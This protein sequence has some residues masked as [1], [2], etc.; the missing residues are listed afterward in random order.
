MRIIQL[1]RHLIYGD[2]ICN[3]II[4]MD[5]ILSPRY[6]SI[7]AVATC[8]KLYSGHPRVVV[9]SELEELSIKED[10]IVIYPFGEYDALAYE[11]L[12]IPCKRVLMYQNV[13]Y[14]YYF[15]GI[16]DIVAV[17]CAKAQQYVRNTP[18]SFLKAIAP[19]AF[20]RKELIDMGWK[21]E[22]IY[23]LPL[24]VSLGKKHVTISDNENAA[25]Q[26]LFVGRIVPNKKIEDVIRVFDYY[27]THY[28]NNSQLRLAGSVGDDAYC[29]ALRKYINLNNIENV[30]FVGRVS[31][32]ELDKLYRSS[33][34]Y[35]CM[36]EHE[37]FCMPLIE[38]M[39]YEI[40]VVAYNAT[41]VPD[42][43]GDA[44]V[45]LESKYSE[46]V[47]EKINRIFEDESYR[48]EL[49]EGQNRHIDNYIRDDYEKK[50][51]DIIE[52]V[53]AISSNSY[54]DSSIEFYKILLEEIEKSGEKY[55][56]EQIQRIKDMDKP[57]VLY[58][59][60]KVGTTLL[61]CFKNNELPIEAICDA[62]K[63]GDEIEGKM[64]MSP[65]ECTQKYPEAIYI[66]T[67][68]NLS[69]ASEI[70]DNLFK[71]GISKTDVFKYFN[72]E[73]KIVF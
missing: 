23:L 45:L 35:L 7:I 69:V 13:T 73:K 41:A 34:I 49:I 43:M 57:I 17:N 21:P 58:G 50:L 47:C 11:L 31:D 59:A 27:R 62:G 15:A 26:F 42:T 22:D 10:D 29:L 39:S 1:R 18:A 48:K 5:R 9:F 33:D 54:D 61:E 4:E 44:G 36:S 52:E 51:C 3:T 71:L 14:P 53:K 12:D 67:V 8:D 16:D 2:G 60:G 63:C 6:K 32:E 72:K 28:Y 25:R 20:S 56:Q 55:L 65:K 38:A 68:Q 24:P 19:S 66:I 37:G 64:I 30:V 40:P 46:Y 70:Y